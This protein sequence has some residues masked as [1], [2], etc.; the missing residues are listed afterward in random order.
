VRLAA[1]SAR[2]GFVFPRRGITVEGCA[3]WF[4]PRIV[5][6]STAIEWCVSG[7][8]FPAAEALE[9]GL[10]RQVVP[11]SEL[12]PAARALAREMVESSAPVSVALTRQM[13]YRMM[14]AG[15]PM[16]AHIME[17]RSLL[18]R[19]GDADSREGV[20]AL[21]EKRAAEFPQRV[22]Q[23]LPDI[24]EGWSAPPWRP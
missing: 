24:W 11:D 14:G 10:V 20:A 23:D 12:L 16:E 8:I 7:R 1:E 3:S 5:G 4:L 22:S 21:R 9:K 17:S 15:H 19:V 18:H 13:I 2:Y 6:P